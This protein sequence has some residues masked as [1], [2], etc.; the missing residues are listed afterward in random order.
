MFSLN[1]NC[2]NIYVYIF[3]AIYVV[4]GFTHFIKLTIIY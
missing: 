4:N 3:I 1:T 2:H